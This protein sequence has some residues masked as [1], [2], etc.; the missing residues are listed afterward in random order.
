[1]SEHLNSV[2]SDVDSEKQ[3]MGSK[4][5]SPPPPPAADQIGL[6]QSEKHKQISIGVRLR[7]WGGGGSSGDARGDYSDTVT[8]IV[9]GSG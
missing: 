8:Q 4:P 2:H 6:Q 9:V 1:M 7:T 3:S 5:P